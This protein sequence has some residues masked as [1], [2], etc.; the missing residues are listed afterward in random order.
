VLLVLETLAPAERAVF[1]LR[2]VFDV[3]YDEIAEA[4]GKSPG[5]GPPDRAPGAGTR[6]GAPNPWGGF[7]GPGPG[8]ARGVL[9]GGRNGRS[10][11]PA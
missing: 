2:E 7:T 11:E 1:V 6:R 8:R 9:A 10:A 4:V 3:A 5:R